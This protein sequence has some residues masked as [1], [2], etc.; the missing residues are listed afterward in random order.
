LRNEKGDLVL[1]VEA[2]IL[3]REAIKK[4]F[5]FLVILS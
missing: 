1:G 3:F 4:P 2:A 5:G